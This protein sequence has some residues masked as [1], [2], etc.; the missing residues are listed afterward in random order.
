MQAPDVEQRL[1]AQ[2]SKFVPTTPE[3]FAKFQH[4][5]AEKWA[6]RSGRP[7]SSQSERM[8]RVWPTTSFKPPWL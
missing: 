7:A 6:R 8:S 3:S 1:E 2:G 4:S 5:E